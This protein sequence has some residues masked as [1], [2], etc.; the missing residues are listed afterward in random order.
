MS[1]KTKEQY[2]ESLRNMKPV[3]YMFG[4]KVKNIV[5]HL[6]CGQGLKLPL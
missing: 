5:D 2:I 1:L 3:A 4:E 6:G